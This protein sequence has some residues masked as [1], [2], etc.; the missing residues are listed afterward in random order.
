MFCRLRKRIIVAGLL[1]L[2]LVIASAFAFK[3]GSGGSTS[4]AS[5]E[6]SFLAIINNYRA[7]KGL[8]ALAVNA[9]LTA[10][11]AWMSKDMAA[12]SYMG[13]TDSLGRSFDVRITSFGNTSFNYLGEN[14]AAGSNFGSAQA[15]FDAWKNSPGHNANMLSTKYNVIGISRAYGSN[16][17]AWFWTTDFGWL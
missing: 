8:P 4:A 3:S 14:L 10:A 12:N 2:V 5:E 13:H 17:G 1:V 7:S 11:A 6:D 9:Q 15:V 16:T